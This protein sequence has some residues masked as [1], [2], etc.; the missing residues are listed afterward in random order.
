MRQA[1]SGARFEKVS[2][3]CAVVQ[4]RRRADRRAGSKKIVGSE[5]SIL[6][7]GTILWTPWRL[8]HRK[9]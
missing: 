8:T 2:T 4:L 5:W 6:V 1:Q 3:E 9:V 7:M